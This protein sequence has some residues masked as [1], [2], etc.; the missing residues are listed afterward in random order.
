MSDASIE[1]T[2]RNGSKWA[3]VKGPWQPS[4]AG[5]LR[6]HELSRIELNTSLGWE[7][8]SL[9]FIS[10]LPIS[11]LSVISSAKIDLPSLV[12]AKQLRSLKLVG[13]YLG[14]LELSE[15]P[16]LTEIAVYWSK[17]ISGLGA[18]GDLKRLFVERADAR[19]I[20][21]IAE[22][23]HQLVSLD[24]STAK[25]PPFEAFLRSERLRE[26]RFRNCRF[27]AGLN[28][29][30][31]V[32]NLEEFEINGG[33]NVD[34]ISD[35]GSLKNLIRLYLLDVGKLATLAPIVDLPI[36]RLGLIGSTC[37]MDGNVSILGNIK[38]LND[39]SARHWRH[40]DSTASEII[41]KTN[42]T[43]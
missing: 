30:G 42:R 9:G 14:T 41:A 7:P 35:I 34:P 20:S 13:P 16:H 21:Q 39:V 12:A 22:I 19:C 18:C 24:I 31:T 1:V 29:I 10:E 38:T 40:Y 4:L 5:Q 43:I 15:L 3:V 17:A 25:L 8:G 11:D 33:K 32:P 6:D 36:E 26:L 28:G 2:D 27:S 23:S 37:I